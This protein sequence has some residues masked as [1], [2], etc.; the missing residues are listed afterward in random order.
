MLLLFLL[1]LT[2]GC[3]MRAK[4]TETAVG[5]CAG[6]TG[7]EGVCIGNG[8]IIGR[9]NNPQNCLTPLSCFLHLKYSG[10]AIVTERWTTVE[11]ECRGDECWFNGQSVRDMGCRECVIRTPDAKTST[12]YCVTP[13]AC[14]KDNR[15]VAMRCE[16]VFCAVNV[17]AVKTLHGR[18]WKHTAGDHG[19]VCRSG[20]RIDV[21][22]RRCRKNLQ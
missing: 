17:G 21:T 22:S 3:R 10:C 14:R 20:N 15:L 6:P 16:G 8:R 11:G 18:C 9:C 4:I 12:G 7:R 2:S 1:A 13:T 5:V 19:Y